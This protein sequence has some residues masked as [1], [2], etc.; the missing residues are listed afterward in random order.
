MS[1]D[2]APLPRKVTIRPAGWVV[3]VLALIGIGWLVWHFAGPH[4]MPLLQDSSGEAGA[5]LVADLEDD[6]AFSNAPQA[7]ASEKAES[8]DAAANDVQTEDEIVERDTAEEDPAEEPPASRPVLNRDVFPAAAPRLPAPA[9]NVARLAWPKQAGIVDSQAG[10]LPASSEREA[11][12]MLVQGSADYAVASITAL[13]AEPDVLKTGAKVVWS[14]GPAPDSA[15]LFPSCDPDALRQTTLGAQTGSAGH[16][17]L[18]AA[19][20]GS[21]AP[22]ITLFDRYEAL[23]KAI[24]E[25]TITGGP[26]LNE[27]A[28]CETLPVAVTTLLV[29]R[30]PE[31]EVDAGQVSAIAMLLPTASSPEDVAS[32]VDEAR[33]TPGGFFEVFQ[34]TQRAWQDAALVAQKTTA[35]E[36]VDRALLWT[37]PVAAD[38]F[39]EAADEELDAE[40]EDE[41][42]FEEDV[43]EEAQSPRPNFGRPSWPD[44]R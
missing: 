36:A 41:L 19:F 39:T 12:R 4:V 8:N 20:A 9:A 38:E 42:A 33:T 35:L 34:K 11:L 22:P 6:E 7:A 5:P 31:V 29:V 25:G 32:F 43:A 3:I 23:E 10:V 44:R 1:D 26:R 37:A 2:D 28:R 30:G 27:G 18:L 15:R 14:L 17:E 21:E 24:A 13:A 16:L 40:V